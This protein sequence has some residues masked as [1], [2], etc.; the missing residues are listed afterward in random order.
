MEPR[1]P[2]VI[3]AHDPSDVP[4][5]LTGAQFSQLAAVK[6]KRV[7]VIPE[8]VNTWG[9]NTVEQ[10]L[11]LLWTAKDI[12]PKQFAYINLV[13]QTQQFYSRF[14]GVDLS[15]TQANDLITSSAGL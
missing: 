6:T 12:Y 3:I 5:L 10:P 13:A 9:D 14:F 4:A 7:N 8:G 2:D 11:G 1:C 15:V